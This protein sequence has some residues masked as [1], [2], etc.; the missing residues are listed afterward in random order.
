MSVV[1]SKILT[2]AS[3]YIHYQV[4]T[5]LQNSVTVH[6]DVPT[7]IIT[8]AARTEAKGGNEPKWRW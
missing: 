5:K 8:P 6:D 1:K 2:A 4:V 3:F 7:V